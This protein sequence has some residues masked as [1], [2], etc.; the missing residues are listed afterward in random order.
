MRTSLF[1]AICLLLACTSCRTT[2]KHSRSDKVESF[3]IY[4]GNLYVSYDANDGTFS[5]RR[6]EKTFIEKASF[7]EGAGESIP[8]VR[9]TRIQDELGSAQ[10]IEV[11]PRRLQK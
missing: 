11:K 6:G 7:I 4:S 2:I 1:T 5:A 3:T 9:A 10:A 8:K